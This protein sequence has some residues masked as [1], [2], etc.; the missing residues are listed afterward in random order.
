MA[1]FASVRHHGWRTQATWTKNYPYLLTA[2]KSPLFLK[3]SVLHH[4]WLVDYKY[5]KMNIVFASAHGQP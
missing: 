1:Q 5:A 2:A 4:V 3:L